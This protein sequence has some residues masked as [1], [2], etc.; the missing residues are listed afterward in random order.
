MQSD[1]LMKLFKDIS[2]EEYRDT[3]K[4]DTALWLIVNVKRFS[5]E[6]GLPLDVGIESG[7]K[8]RL[9][10]PCLTVGMTNAGEYRTILLTADKRRFSVLVSPCNARCDFPFFER[11]YVFEWRKGNL[12]LLP[13][14]LFNDESTISFCGRCPGEMVIPK[15]VMNACFVP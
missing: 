4:A 11:S 8:H 9:H 12:V 6:S 7:K 15:D 2:G 1:E 5:R 10:R 3:A 14:D 13:A